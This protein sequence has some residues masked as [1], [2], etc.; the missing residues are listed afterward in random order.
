MEDNFQFHWQ[1]T[2]NNK[3]ENAIGRTMKNLSSLAAAAPQRAWI[4]FRRVFPRISFGKEERN[5]ENAKDE[6]P[7]NS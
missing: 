6:A 3:N 2:E 1:S 5:M 4:Q 7:K